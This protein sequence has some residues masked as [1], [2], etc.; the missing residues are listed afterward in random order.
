MKFGGICQFLLRDMGYFSKYV[1]GCRIPG[2]T[3]Q[4]LSDA[5]ELELKTA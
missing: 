1:K 2:T 4:G 3:F 5:S